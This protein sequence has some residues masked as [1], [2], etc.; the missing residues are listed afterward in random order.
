MKQMQTSEWSPFSWSFLLAFCC[1]G[2]IGNVSVSN[3]QSMQEICDNALDDDDDGLIDLNDPDCGCETLE[4]VSLI[5]N[6]SFED[7]RCCPIGRSQMDCAEGWIQ[8][9]APTTDFI[10]T[11]DWQGWEQ[12][13]PPQP[14]PDGEG[15]MGFRDGRVPRNGDAPETNWKEYAGACLL[16]PLKKNVT[17]R[18][19]FHMGFVDNISSPPINITF[20][21]TRS[22]ENLPFGGGN[23]DF[24]CPTNGPDWTQLGFV[25]ASSS[26]NSWKKL[27]IEVTPGEDIHAIAIGPPCAASQNSTNT[28]YFFDNLV[29]AD[30]RS[31]EFQI[32]GIEHPCSKDFLL[33]VPEEA[34]LSYQ[35]FKNGVALLGETA[36]TLS[37]MAGE[38]LYQVRILDDQIC[39]ITRAYP[40]Q[41]P[42]FSESIQVTICED[43]S[44]AFGDQFLDQSGVYIDTFKTSQGCDSIVTLSLQALDEIT[45]TVHAKIFEGNSYLIGQRKLTTKGKHSVN[46]QSS[47]GCDSLVEVHLDF[48]NVFIPNIFSPN[49][50]GMNDYFT[51]YGNHDLVAILNLSIFDRWG[52]MIFKD[53][54]GS[55]EEIS[56]DGTFQGTELKNG[57]Y[58]YQV[59][60]LMQDGTEQQFTGSVTVLK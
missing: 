46:L 15:I 12:F 11:C 21:G 19:E 41:V 4:P 9:S 10:H 48:F 39:M 42:T 52:T 30:L 29:L 25:N 34:N 7:R 17:Y 5:P 13:P 43:E 51:I 27:S 2:F 50:D 33:A 16:S 3:S 40:F 35:W 49:G 55:N 56:W 44:Y 54:G 1:I 38:G 26:N 14:Y 6:P 57:V 58:V 45:N 8:A 53:D 23:E 24:G 37:K 60:V 36:S 22:C 18:F 32:S 59:A 31:F 47:I 28:Y 20:F